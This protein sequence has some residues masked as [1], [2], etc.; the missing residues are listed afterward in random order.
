MF[1]NIYIY[2][3][4]VCVNVTTYT[5]SKS[6]VSTITTFRSNLC[7]QCWGM[8]LVSR[9]ALVTGKDQQTAGAQADLV[10]K[11]RSHGLAQSF[12]HDHHHFHDF[13]ANQG[14]AARAFTRFLYN[15][16]WTWTCWSSNNTLYSCN[17]HCILF[18][19]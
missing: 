16:S 7:S 5:T 6:F 10:I 18:C 8:S 12:M 2:I 3:V 1:H 9:L 17:S 19:T 14:G 15:C 13:A 11:S 4:C